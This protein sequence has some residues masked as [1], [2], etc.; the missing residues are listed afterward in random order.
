MDMLLSVYNQHDKSEVADALES[1]VRE[2]ARQ[3]LVVALDEE[4]SA[5]LGRNRYERKKGLKG[6]RIGYHPVREVTVGVSPV[7][8]RVPRVASVPDGISTSL[9]ESQIGLHC[10]DA[11]DAF[12]KGRHCNQILRRIS[13]AKVVH[14]WHRRDI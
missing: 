13:T 7:E 12:R 2:G 11:F 9:F 1:Y 8:V 10:H 3:M 4:V 6:Y 14:V 5:F